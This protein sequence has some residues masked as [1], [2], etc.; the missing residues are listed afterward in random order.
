MAH[1]GSVPFSLSFFSWGEGESRHRIRSVSFYISLVPSGTLLPSLSKRWGRGT[2]GI[3]LIQAEIW[4]EL[5]QKICPRRGC[6]WSASHYLHHK[7]IMRTS[8]SHPHANPFP[9]QT[10][11]VGMA[12]S[13][14]CLPVQLLPFFLHPQAQ[15]VWSLLVPVQDGGIVYSC[16]EHYICLSL[17]SCR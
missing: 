14:I 17:C 16:F 4:E 12:E 3:A 9:C 13:G 10:L 15:E 6:Q 5:A 1:I 7:W 2:G 11:F 8:T